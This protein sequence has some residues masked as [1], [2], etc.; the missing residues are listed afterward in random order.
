MKCLKIY[1]N[2]IIWASF[3]WQNA[4]QLLI[5]GYHHS[6]THNIYKTLYLQFITYFF[7]HPWKFWE[8]VLPLAPPID[9]SVFRVREI[10]KSVWIKL[11]VG[12]PVKCEIQKF[13][14]VFTF[15]TMTISLG[16]YTISQSLSWFH[17]RCWRC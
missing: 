14:D 16:I 9:T 15:D 7:W 10:R 1:F 4:L 11:S 17:W 2:S 5:S 6:P 3:Y 8:G 13:H 12:F